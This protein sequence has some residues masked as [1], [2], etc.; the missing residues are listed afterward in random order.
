MPTLTAKI[1]PGSSSLPF[2]AG[3]R[4]KRAKQPGPGSVIELLP[5]DND[6]KKSLTV[7]R[8]QFRRDGAGWECKEIIG[9][10]E[11]RKRVYLKHLS[12]TRYQKMQSE[13]ATKAEL[14]E[15]L[16]TWA[17]KERDRKRNG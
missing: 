2:D 17:D 7:G 3:T 14:E 1:G 16:I 4:S 11:S 13:S 6:E 15:K 8:Y 10:G 5:T 12:R 9:K